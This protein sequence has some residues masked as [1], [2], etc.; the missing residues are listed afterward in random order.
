MF[1]RAFYELHAK[2]DLHELFGQTDAAMIARLRD[3]ARGGPWD[4][5][6]SG[7]F[8]S[9]R[10]L[11]KRAAEFGHDQDDGGSIYARLAGRPYSEIVTAA[12][13]L[14]KLLSSQLGLEV[15]PADVLI[16]APPAHR[17]VEF[18]VD[19]YFPK[20]DAYRPLRRVSPVVD[21][22]ARTQFD[23]YVKRV[24]IFVAP[25]LR[26]RVSQ[27]PSLPQAVAEAVAD[28]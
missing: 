22:L 25:N 23:E 16:D 5:L 3:V 18:A 28:V 4:R 21:S 17:E 14:A 13:R 7:A 10:N 11:Y 24:R 20:Q 2:L 6:L 27:L 19:I 1:A 12:T 26:D 9:Q 15:A 8:G